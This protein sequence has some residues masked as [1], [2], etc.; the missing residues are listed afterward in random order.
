MPKQKKSREEFLFEIAKEFK[1]EL[2]TDKKILF[3]KVCE[4]ELA[5]EKRSQVTQHLNANV[6]KKKLL[7]RPSS[8]QKLLPNVLG[9]SEKENQL[10]SAISSEMCEAFVSGLFSSPSII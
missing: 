7:E 10:V 9:K 4:R 1:D 8:S 5:A 6:H 3:C 2:E